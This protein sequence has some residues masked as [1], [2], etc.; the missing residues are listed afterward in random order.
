MITMIVMTDGR[1][2]CLSRSMATLGRLRGPVTMRV[3]HDDSGSPGYA[4]HLA[5]NYPEWQIIS[6]GRRSGFAGAY[7]N[8]WAWLRRCDTEFVFSTEDD[9]RFVADVDLGAMG[10][11]L[12]RHPH[13]TQMALLR[14]PWNDAEKTAGGII[15]MDR[16]SYNECTDGAHHWVQHRKFFTT[17]PH[18]IRTAFIRGHD[19]PDGRQSEGRFS[20]DLF[21]RDPAATSAFWGRADD[22]PRVEHIGTQR[23]GT[24]Y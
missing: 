10:S 22:P 4:R 15:A 6:T 16:P 19:W 1:A 18:M 17:N 20:A 9:F 2:E 7:R 5:E 13:V 21:R 11:V 14:Q 8:A 3:I 23:V 24:G 12:R